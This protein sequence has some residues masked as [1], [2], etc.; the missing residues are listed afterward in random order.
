MRRV[1]SGAVPGL[2]LVAALLC[3]APAA[4]AQRS[5]GG[6]GGGF[7]GGHAGGFS[8]GFASHGFG[9]GFSGSAGRSSFAPRSYTSAPRMN[10]AAPGRG[11]TGAYR[12]NLSAGRPGW[13]GQGRSGNRY[14]SPYRGYGRYGGY[15]YAVGNS[16]ELTPWELGYPDFLGYGNDIGDPQPDAQI[17]QDSAD[18]GPAPDDE[19]RPDYGAAP[20]YAPSAPAPVGSEPALTLIFS[21]GHRQS[22]R[23]YALTGDSV[24]VLDGAAA[25]RQQR[26]PLADLNL[27]ATQQAAQQSGL[28]FTPPA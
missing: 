3:V 2:L 8:G 9:G 5:G 6:H 26:I 20:G 13:A 27:T 16:W 24:I 4:L 18:A 10:W 14:R 17:P 23:N 7:G 1:F 25:G 15:P 28:D 11:F 21:D 22:I 12:G 19:Y